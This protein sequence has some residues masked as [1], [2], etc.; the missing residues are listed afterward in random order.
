MH[1]PRAWGKLSAML[2]LTSLS[3]IVFASSTLALTAFAQPAAPTQPQA[4]AA[5][6][7]PSAPAQPRAAPPAAPA[8]PSTAAPNAAKPAAPAAASGASAPRAAVGPSLAQP[9]PRQEPQAPTADTSRV[10]LVEQAGRA[11]ALGT[12][13]HGDGRVLTALSRVGGPNPL[14]VRYANGAI[15]PARIGHSDPGK[16]LALLVP[17]VARSRDGV[18]A[19]RAQQAPQVANLSGF[20]LSANRSVT[21][22]QYAT[23]LAT[24]SPGHTLLELTPAPKPADLGGPLLDAQGQALAVAISGCAG[25]AT[26]TGCAA[27]PVGLPVAQV[28]AF[29]RDLPPQA[30]LAVPWLGI[31]GV[32]ADTGVARGI[33][34]ASV[35]PGSPAAALGLRAG[36]D[37]AGSDIVV[38]VGGT[39][40]PNP[41][42]L[43]ATL[44][45]HS[46]RER[47]VLL[48]FGKDG[49]RSVP[50]RLAEKPAT[51]APKPAPT[52]P[53]ASP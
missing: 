20:T 40:V 16:D 3:S 31:Q 45:R 42:A 8:Q 30:D 19:A 28:R 44:A 2:R 9:P 14:F 21:P 33:R 53:K 27:A 51:P 15:E 4:P 43:R 18:K 7:A 22:T 36:A 26:S 1:S 17:K 49:Y 34:I 11:V 12:L 23:T 50:V 6:R 39:P 35:D 46:S 13:L 10:V 32:A 52:A 41:E 38:A 24:R 25:A 47:V 37:P 5:P 48:V 29:L